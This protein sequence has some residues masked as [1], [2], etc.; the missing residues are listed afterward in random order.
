MKLTFSSNR[1]SR[2]NCG[3]VLVEGVL[4]MTLVIGITVAA[5]LFLVNLIVIGAY[6]EKLQSVAKATAD[7]VGG[8]EYWLGMRRPDFDEATA[9]D[10]GRVLARKLLEKVGMPVDCDVS[11]DRSTIQ[12]P[13]LNGTTKVTTVSISAS[14]LPLIGKYFGRVTGLTVSAT[15]I[16]NAIAPYAV[17]RHSYSAPN[18]PN[19]IKV[20]YVPAYG[21]A[22]ANHP[23]LSNDYAPRGGAGEIGPIAGPLNLV[24][25]TSGVTDINT[26]G[27]LEVPQKGI[28][29]GVKIPGTR[30]FW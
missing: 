3:S 22:W 14:A 16:E 27:V 20:I 7:Y 15:S 26:F 18:N 5:V 30:A 23:T 2:K 28:E 11:Y 4:S 10:Q 1:N 9:L 13:E 19:D 6:R 21:A 24:G 12:L 25:G 17:A 29:V 8:K